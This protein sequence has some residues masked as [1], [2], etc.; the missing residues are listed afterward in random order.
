MLNKSTIFW[1]RTALVTSFLFLTGLQ[2]TAKA[3]TYTYT[4][5]DFQTAT[6]PY[7]LTDF[8]SGFFT[9]ASP[10]G[11]N[12]ALGAITPTSY[13]FTDGVQTFSSA[14]PPSGVTFKVA[15]DASGNLNGWF[16]DLQS[17]VNFVSTATTPN[18]E[19]QGTSGG[20]AA[21][22]FFDEGSW[23]ASA[24]GGGGSTVPE[25][26]YAVL[27]AVGLVGIAVVRRKLGY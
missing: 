10:L 21:L 27:L 20:G 6:S 25:P 19:D 13:S 3:E 24:S 8:V 14:S 23:Q 11:D 9:V 22:N 5:N 15:T 18:Q 1:T 7:T 4:G 2:S 16:I 12:L 17:G 26:G